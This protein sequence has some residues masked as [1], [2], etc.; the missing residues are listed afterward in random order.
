LVKI[1]FLGKLRDVAGAARR[2]VTGH[3][4]LSAYLAHLKISEPA[5]H[6]ALTQ[7]GVHCALNLLLL[8]QCEDVALSEGDELA[9]MPAFSG[10]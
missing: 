10:G 8:S 6:D 1:V 5:L 7:Q 9:F 3:T 4:S 2:D